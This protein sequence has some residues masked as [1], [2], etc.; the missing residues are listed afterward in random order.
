LPARA[1]YEQS[2]GNPLFALELLRGQTLGY[3][4]LPIS[5]ARAVRDRL[6]CLPP[7]AYDVLRWASVL[8][9]TF[10][11]ELLASLLAMAGDEVVQALEVLGKRALLVAGTASGFRFSH[12]VVRRVVYADLSEPRRR[13]MHR[14]VAQALHTARGEQAEIDDAAV[15]EVAR[16]ATLGHDDDLAALACRQAG[17]RCVKMFANEAALSL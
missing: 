13:S 4:A 11:A 5:L 14:R 1:V 8:G 2:G 9:S 16:H 3:D 12:D 17:R 10:S 15:A 7:S 6:E